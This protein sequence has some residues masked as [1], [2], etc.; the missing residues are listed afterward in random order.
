M[1]ILLRALAATAVVAGISLMP[2]AGA[3]AQV[4]VSLYP[5]SFRY[6]VPR[7]AAQSG[8]ITVTNPSATP[9]SLQVE[10]ENFSG[11]EGGTVEY[12]PEGAKYGLLSWIEIDRTPFVLAPGEKREVPFTVRVPDNAEVGGHYGAVLFRAGGAEG[13]SGASEIGVSGRIGSII[14]VS[15]PGDV[16]RS[17]ELVRVT[18][19]SFVQNGPL[20]LTAAYKNT[21]SVHYVTKGTATFRGIFGSETV[22]F[23]EKTVLPDVQ[24]DTIATLDKKWL[25]GPVFMT[26]TLE[27][28]D[29]TRSVAKATT[30]AFPVLPGAAAI[31]LA[32][33]A[34]A[35]VRSAKRRFRIVRVGE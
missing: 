27:S 21:G 31:V 18:A 15:V 25:V 14:L 23:E 10:V 8:V 16:Q 30:F 24:R 9:L 7:G 26:A 35:A 17:G 4:S 22:A 6:D 11:G 3:L 13:G 33:L 32:A 5:I 2:V 34:Y 1:K 20:T 29:G 19:P 28:G 12:A